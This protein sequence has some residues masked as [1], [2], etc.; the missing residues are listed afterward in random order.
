M[1]N[2]ELPN[3]LERVS[4]NKLMS[5]VITSEGEPI[6]SELKFDFTKLGFIEPSGV[7]ALSNLFEWL[8][9]NEVKASIVYPEEFGN[10]KWCPIQYLDDSEFFLKYL[11][12]N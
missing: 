6:N 5:Q 4:V 3:R 9:K 11:G 10:T 8:L 12:K 1:L 2:I 7:T